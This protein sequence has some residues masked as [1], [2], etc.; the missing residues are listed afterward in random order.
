MANSLYISFRL[1]TTTPYRRSSSSIYDYP[2]SPSPY[3]PVDPQPR[4]SIEPS[5]I[6]RNITP[7]IISRRGRGLSE[8]AVL[9]LFNHALQHQDIYSNG[10]N[11]RMF[12]M[13]LSNCLEESIGR[14][15]HARSCKRTIQNYTAKRRAQLNEL[16]ETGRRSKQRDDLKA[17]IDD[18]IGVEDRYNEGIQRSKEK[19]A[20]T[21]R[22]RLR[23]EVYRE[24][25]TE[26][27]GSKRLLDDDDEDEAS[28]DT[29]AIK[30]PRSYLIM[31]V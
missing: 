28:L 26:T 22:D 24:I 14:P 13:I 7:D 3:P 21:E 30:V 1:P 16:S 19:K 12:W 18:W 29:P 17:A 27:R 31:I 9:A 15:Y 2:L 4:N 25:L 5:S 20:Y 8:S 6:E 23:D 10:K 11:H